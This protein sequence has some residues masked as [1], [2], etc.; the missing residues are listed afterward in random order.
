MR[1]HYTVHLLKVKRLI[2]K[3]TVLPTIY[4]VRRHH[5]DCL[6]TLKA[7]LTQNHIHRDAL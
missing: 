4:Q 3:R 7:R 2:R 6:D 5:E 1:I